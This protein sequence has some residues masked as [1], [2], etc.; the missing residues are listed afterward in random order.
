MSAGGVLQKIDGDKKSEIDSGKAQRTDAG[1]VGRGKR[2]DEK[3]NLP[4]RFAINYFRSPHF[5]G[6]GSDRGRTSR[7][8]HE[9]ARRIAESLAVKTSNREGMTPRGAFSGFAR[10]KK[11][12][13]FN[14]LPKQE[15]GI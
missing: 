2:G 9:K 14:Y 3:L 13:N 4:D 7:E 15:A 6:I 11:R 10:G 8:R 1:Q 12:S 5:S